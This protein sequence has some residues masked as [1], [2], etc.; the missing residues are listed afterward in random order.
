MAAPTGSFVRRL[1]LPPLLL[2]LLSRVL[3]AAAA[4]VAAAP[5]DRSV[6]EVCIWLCRLVLLPPRD[7]RVEGEVAL[8]GNGHRHVN[9]AC[10]ERNSRCI[11]VLTAMKT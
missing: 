3:H 1:L 11:V 9:G 8:Q 5:L 2:L 6:A 10:R 7:H 4:A